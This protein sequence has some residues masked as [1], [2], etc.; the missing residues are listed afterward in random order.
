MTKGKK[1]KQMN[2][3]PRVPVVRL[4]GAGPHHTRRN[5]PTR[6]QKYK[7]GSHV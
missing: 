6:K 7:E 1:R 4:S 5:E 2:R 3:R